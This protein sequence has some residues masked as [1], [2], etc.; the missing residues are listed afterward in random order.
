[1]LLHLPKTL[2]RA[3]QKHVNAAFLCPAQW[4]TCVRVVTA[5]IT[6]AA[7]SIAAMSTAAAAANGTAAV[8][9]NGK[10]YTV[11][12]EGLAKTLVPYTPTDPKPAGKKAPRNDES[13]QQV[14]YNPIQQFNRD[15]SVL[16]IKAYGEEALE[17]KAAAAARRQEHQE[18]KK[19]K[20]LEAEGAS[21]RRQKV[22]KLSADE[23]G[24]EA[25]A[26]AATKAVDTQH[27]SAAVNGEATHVADAVAPT[28]KEAEVPGEATKT[29]GIKLRI[30]DALSA[31]GL[32]ALRYAHEL[33]FP[34]TVT[35]NDLLPTAVETIKLNV[36]YND[37][38]DKIQAIE[39]DALIHMYSLASNNHRPQGQPT[40][41][42]V[43]DLDPY[44][45]AAPFFDAAVLAV[46]DGGLL[47]VTCTDA[48]VWA[49]NGYQEKAF[50]LYG[51]IPMKGAL[52]HEAGIRLVL[53]GIAAAAAKHGRAI[54]PLLS[55]SIDFY[56]RIFIRVKYSPAAVKFLAGNTMVVHNCDSGCGA[57]TTQPLLRN[58]AV[59]AKGKAGAYYKHTA[60]RTT[61]PPS[62][63]H[64][65]QKTHVAGPMYAGRMHSATFIRRILDDLPQASTDTYKTTERIRGM[66]QTALEELDEDSTDETQGSDCAAAPRDNLDPNPFF[67]LTQH[68]TRIIHCQTPS[69]NALRGALRGLGYRVTR[70]HCRPGSIKTNA[71][72]SVI[73][74]VMREWVRQKAPV[75]EDQFQPGTPGY[76]LLRL[77]PDPP[78][79]DPTKAPQREEPVKREVV[80]DEKLGRESSTGQGK[81]VRYQ[82]NP[83]ENWGPMNRAKG[84]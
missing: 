27:E 5:A 10:Q 82:L 36:E 65:G 39:S 33:P 22:V 8:E 4:S 47:C 64:C 42:D 72:W 12:T 9:R 26:V 50:A 37:L 46:R 41:Y 84:R 63:E 57:W 83:R 75:K 51:G 52:S 21:D 67:F 49:G 32:R 69:D 44:G 48:A 30:L 20:R 74:E 31:S 2:P 16:A 29:M 66:L 25:A 35:A 80:F 23:A 43:I 14:F 62:C 13:V 7:A 59:E 6:P 78:A 17:K 61:A 34:V 3:A 18:A 70:S 40:K 79:A 76:R 77:G 71:P 60:A 56:C 58:T 24:D 45:T 19:R 15:L 81:L 55:L 68:L 1:M 11:I 54:E 38:A 53:H 28:S 73:W